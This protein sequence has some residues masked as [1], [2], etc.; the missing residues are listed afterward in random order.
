MILSLVYL[1]WQT[2]GTSNTCGVRSNGV[3]KNREN[4]EEHD[5][6]CVKEG[7]QLVRVKFDLDEK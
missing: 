4:H 5:K 7:S 6:D 2:F 1:T 3:G